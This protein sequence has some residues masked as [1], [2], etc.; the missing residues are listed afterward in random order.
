MDLRTYLFQN[1]ITQL[2]FANE[3]ECSKIT[4]SHIV[5]GKRPSKRI[6]KRIEKVTKGAVTYPE[7]L[8]KESMNCVD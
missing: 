8:K 1:R 2:E 6:A 5:A 7:I 4:I 3:V